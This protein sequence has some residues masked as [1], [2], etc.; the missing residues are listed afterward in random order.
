MP[1]SR[2]RRLHKTEGQLADGHL[3]VH[4]TTATRESLREYA[5]ALEKVY[6]VV[7]QDGAEEA[8]G[9]AQDMLQGFFYVLLGV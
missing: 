1:V 7:D 8:F 3:K 4:A 2:R 9:F 5:C 6:R